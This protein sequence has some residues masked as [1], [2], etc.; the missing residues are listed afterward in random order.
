MS[1]FLIFRAQEPSIPIACTEKNFL[2]P[3][4]SLINATCIDLSNLTIF[5]EQPALRTY[6]IPAPGLN[7]RFEIF[8][9][10]GRSLINE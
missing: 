6:L 3:D 5:A 2:T 9:N 8:L 7:S 4:G 1:F 10:A